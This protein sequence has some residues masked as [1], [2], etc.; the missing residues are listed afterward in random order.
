MV[1]YWLREKPKIREVRCL[2]FYSD[3][4]TEELITK[5]DCQSTLLTPT[6]NSINQSKLPSPA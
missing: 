6:A 2:S 4:Q 1:F 5:I 3:A